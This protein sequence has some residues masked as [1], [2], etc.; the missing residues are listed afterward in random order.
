MVR[1]QALLAQPNLLQLL[2]KYFSNMALHFGRGERRGFYFYF[3]FFQV[4]SSQHLLGQRCPTALIGP[5]GSLGPI[6]GL[7]APFLL[8]SSLSLTSH[9]LQKFLECFRAQRVHPFSFSPLCQSTASVFSAFEVNVCFSSSS[10]FLYKTLV[11]ILLEMH[12]S[13]NSFS[14]FLEFS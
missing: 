13:V 8:I 2:Q 11:A 1:D 3:L 14:F 10:Y 4:R 7:L 6:K 9:L 5:L 12:A